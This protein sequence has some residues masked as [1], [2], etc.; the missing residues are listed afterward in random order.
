MKKRGY[1]GSYGNYILIQHNRDYAT[2]YA[3]LSR[4]AKGQKKGTYVKQGEIIAYVGTTGRSTAPHLH[5][6][7]HYKKKQVNPQKIKCHLNATY[8]ALKSKTLLPI[9]A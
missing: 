4:F 2:A 5:Y 1:L 9:C 3:H 7:I 8:R 6:E